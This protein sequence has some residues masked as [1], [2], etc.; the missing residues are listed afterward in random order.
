MGYRMNEDRTIQE[1]MTDITLMKQV[2][3]KKDHT[4]L[5]NEWMGAKHAA[6]EKLSAYANEHM[7]IEL[8]C[9]AYLEAQFKHIHACM[10]RLLN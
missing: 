1:W 5:Q 10:R 4:A 8:D 9:G 2:I 3:T 7:G 6:K